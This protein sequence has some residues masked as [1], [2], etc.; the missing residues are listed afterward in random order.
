MNGTVRH[1]LV[2]E[3]E[4]A[5]SALRRCARSDSAAHDV[6][7]ELKRARATLRILR[8]A[9]GETLY[10]QENRIIRDAARPLTA[11]RDAEVLAHT[12]TLLNGAT[13]PGKEQPFSRYAAR[14]LRQEQRDSRRRLQRKTLAATAAALRNVERRIRGIPGAQLDRISL[15]VALARVYKA[16]RKAF[17]RARQD[18]TDERLHEWR[19][20][21]QYFLN[22]VELVTRLTAAHFAKR[23]KRLHRL[24]DCLGEDHDLAVLHQRIM[25]F[26]KLRMSADQT[27]TVRVWV[28]RLRR[29]RAALQRRAQRLGKGLYSDKPRRVESKLEKRLSAARRRRTHAAPTA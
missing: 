1:T 21:V 24:A 8:Q 27:D 25:Q 4:H 29:H 3:L 9:I 16:G 17:V 11:V 15:S 5:R 26:S 18:P 22:Q 7:K 19:K 2:E 10:R 23:R 20:Q 12:M 13:A 6:R 28:G 14:L